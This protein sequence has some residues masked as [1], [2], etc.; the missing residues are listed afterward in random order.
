[1]LPIIVVLV[2]VFPTTHMRMRHDP[3]FSVKCL[4]STLAY[5][6]PIGTLWTFEGRHKIEGNLTSDDSIRVTI[7]EEAGTLYNLTKK[8]HS[9]AFY[10]RSGASLISL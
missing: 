6:S 7:K 5:S 3:A 10:M 8:V 9:F 4:P 2:L 1:M